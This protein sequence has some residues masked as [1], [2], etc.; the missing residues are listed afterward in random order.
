VNSVQN[1]RKNGI[2]TDFWTCLGNCSRWPVICDETPE[3]FN[4]RSFVTRD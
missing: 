2:I 3:V 4:S 1:E